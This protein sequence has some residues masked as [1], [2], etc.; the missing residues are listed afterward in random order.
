[1]T[2][3]GARLGA[4]HGDAWTCFSDRFETLRPVF[5]AELAAV[6]RSTDE[7]PILVAVTVEEALVGL[8]ELT[9]RWH[10]LGA[11]EIIVHD[12][13]PHELDDILA[14]AD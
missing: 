9:A 6:G 14:L 2:P 7:V 11:S 10:E 12:I 3:K 1:M 13:H 8:A 5:L 4:R